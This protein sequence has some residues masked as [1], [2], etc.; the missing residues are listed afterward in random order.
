MIHL[1]AEVSEAVSKICIGENEQR[2]IGKLSWAATKLAGLA[3]KYEHI[4]AD[5]VYEAEFR[6][7]NE[8]KGELKDERSGK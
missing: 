6:A 4:I 5:K 1:L 8:T 7:L 3:E 2:N